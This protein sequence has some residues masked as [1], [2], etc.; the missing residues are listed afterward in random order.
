[1]IGEPIG[2]GAFAQ[3][4]IAF[5]HR[6]R[7]PFA[8]KVIS[9]S[10]LAQ[11]K[12]GRLMLFNETV[13]APLVDHPSIVEIVEIADSHSQIFQFMRFAEHGDLLHR[14]WKAPF[15]Q[16]IAFRVIDQ[17][18]SAVEYLHANGIV[19]RDI[20]LE[21]IL[22]SKH[23]GAKLCDFGLA[24]ITF[25][26][27]VSGNC[28]SFEYSAPEAIKQPTFNGFKADMW[29]VGVVIYAIFARR[30]PFNVPA[31]AP[32]MD[33]ADREI[34]YSQ[35]IDMSMI[36]ESV[37]PLISQLLSL[38]PDERP[39]ATEAR[40]FACLNSSQTKKKEPLSMLTMPDFQCE[41]A[42]VIISRL[43]Q[44][45]HISFQTMI[46]KLRDPAM[47]RHKLLFSL[48]KKRYEK[49]NLAGL[50][51]PFHRVL[52]ANSE[53]AP[54]KMLNQSGT[55]LNAIS[56]LDK[57]PLQ[58]EKAFPISSNKLYDQMHSF[59]LKRKC[60]VSSPISTTPVI[61]QHIE[62]R[63]IRLSFTCRDKGP[64]D[65]DAVLTLIADPESKDLSNL[66]MTHME[67]CFSNSQAASA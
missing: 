45:L 38:N 25:N 56:T 2:H 15:E 36:P 10:K 8:V 37:R 59:L 60:C 50:D 21:N 6:S 44:A 55:D 22:L 16:S 48:Y 43:S 39:S 51:L 28:G 5:H 32:G 1:M 27:I 19:H 4:R 30:L 35:P 47:N 11:S 40:G 33:P 65:S 20:K 34:D 62:G 46:Q 52:I 64:D 41:N 31:V 63:D 13:L 18:L 61:I 29:S 67:Q 23:T 9:K 42:F 49:L 58:N 17:I 26:G 57:I 53:P 66:I 54:E 3:I 24:S 14:L 12:N 7:N